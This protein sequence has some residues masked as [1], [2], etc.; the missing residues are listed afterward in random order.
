MTTTTTTPEEQ[1]RVISEQSRPYY[2]RQ[3]AG[4]REVYALMAEIE[5]VR[6]T[7]KSYEQRCQ[8]FDEWLYGYSGS[9]HYRGRIE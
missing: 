7:G 8:D 4:L 5:A 3:V 9:T 2:E 1:Q 6:V